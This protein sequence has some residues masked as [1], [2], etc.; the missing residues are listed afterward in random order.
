M[1]KT[2]ANGS[3]RSMHENL[4]RRETKLRKGTSGWLPGEHGRTAHA[5]VRIEWGEW[6]WANASHL[7]AS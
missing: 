5:N 7:R 3:Q 6:H 1:R 2:F 4:H